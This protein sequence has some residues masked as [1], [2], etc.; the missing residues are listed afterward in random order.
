MCI[1]VYYVKRSDGT[2]QICNYDNDCPLLWFIMSVTVLQYALITA[3]LLSHHNQPITLNIV[4]PDS[5]VEV[6]VGCSVSGL[7]CAIDRSN[8]YCMYSCTCIYICIVCM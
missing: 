1:I 2:L 7:C 3:L 4:L 5:D 8:S 6:T